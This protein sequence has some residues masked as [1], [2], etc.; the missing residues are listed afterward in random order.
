MAQEIKGFAEHFDGFKRHLKLAIATFVAIVAIGVGFAYSLPDV[1]RSQGYI[2]IEEAAIP[3]EILRSTVTTYATRQLTT[4]NERI[5]TIPTL[6]SLVEQFNLYPDE[7]G[8]TPV[9]LLAAKARSAIAVEIQ[10]RDSVSPQGLP[11]LQ[12]VGFTVSFE[13]ENPESA[14]AVADELVAMYLEE[15]IKTRSQQTTETADFLS[16]EVSQL[17]SEIAELE[18]KLAKF[19]EDNADRLPSLNSLNMQMMQR[20]DQQLLQLDGE[21]QSLNQLRISIEAQLAT[22]DSSVPA[23]L[24]D[25]SFALSPLD[26]LKQLQ[27]QLSVYESRYSD[28]HPDV[29][30]TR[31]DIESLKERF[32]I[33]V[34]MAQLD[35]QLRDARAAL[36]VLLEKYS[37]DHPD[38]KAQQ[39]TIGQLER[40]ISDSLEKQLAGKV[41]PDNPAYIQLQTQLATISAEEY[42]IKKQTDRL[43]TDMADYERRLMETPQVEKELAALSRTLSSTSN[44]YWVMRDKQF[45]AEMGETLETEN[46]GEEMVLIEPPRVPLKPYK[47]NRGA[48]VTLS[49]LF[50]LVAGIG[51]TQLVDSMDKSI[52]SA[53]AIVGVQGQPPLVEVPYIFSDDELLQHARVKKMAV[54]GLAPLLLIAVMI[55][56]FT[57]LP[58]DVLW[59]SVMNRIGF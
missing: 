6:I 57:V 42:A 54:A 5:L 46:K 50:A 11:Q 45:A 44:R 41:E 16:G 4:L 22:V 19:K 2:L 51:I 7:R 8:N 9:E 24:P 15:N 18:A 53:S 49:L 32:G 39:R 3:E 58:I 55:V 20:I 13:D 52:R 59:Y 14:K 12:A 17:E 40:D 47:P 29:V 27:S 38:V 21:L 25:G 35:D 28:D 1:Y 33:D 26:Q 37:P 30:A 56:H 23:R 43:R 34:D 36:A 10:S 31:R 48:I